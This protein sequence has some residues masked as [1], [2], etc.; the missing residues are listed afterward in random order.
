MILRLN[1]VLMFAAAVAGLTLPASAVD[2]LLVNPGFEGP[3]AGAA[4]G[5]W[6]STDFNNFWGSNVH[7]SLYGDI[8]F[9]SGGVFQQGIVGQPGTSYQFVLVDTRI[10]PNWDADLYFGFE[11]YAS[12]DGTKL[13]ETM[14]LAD[15]ATRVANAQV[16]GNVFAMQGTAVAG[17]AYVRPVFRFDNVNPTYEYQPSANTFVFD[18]FLSL[19]P[20]RGEEYLMNP[21]LEDINTDGAYGD[22]WRKWGTVDFNSFWG[23]NGHASFFADTIGNA[24]GVWQ[25][26]I[27][28]TPG[29][30]YRFELQDVRVEANW[31]ADLYF[32][33]EYYGADDF[34][35]IG[36]TI[37]LADTAQTGDG[38]HYSMTAT[39]PAGTVYIRPSIRFDN[40]GST[41]GSQRN[42]FVFTASLTYPLPLPGDADDDGDID[43]A[44]YAAMAGCLQGPGVTPSG[45]NCL[46]VFDGD[47]DGDVDLVDFSG[48]QYIFTGELK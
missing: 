12:D 36:E 2:N 28:G 20:A 29:T 47:D 22:Y 38:L 14:V 27:L 44:D 46:T 4:W 37:V 7:A 26:G 17:T 42:L 13:G 10:E 41:G 9:N 30:R 21:G 32:G 39:A 24:G 35:K 31:D 8:F 5:N 25:Q 18:T 43:L 11:Y 19:S 3:P 23:M 48:F 15:T 1:T 33:L 40:V 34:T 16:D 6:G 45:P